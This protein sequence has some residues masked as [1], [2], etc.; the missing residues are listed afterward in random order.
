MANRKPIITSAEEFGID[1]TQLPGFMLDRDEQARSA[2]LRVELLVKT[3]PY[4]DRLI[5]N[6]H[7]T[8]DRILAAGFIDTSYLKYFSW[9]VGRCPTRNYI[10]IFNIDCTPSLFLNKDGTF[11]IELCEDLPRNLTRL[12]PEIE[13]YEIHSR[14]RPKDPMTVREIVHYGSARA[15]LSAAIAP[16]VAFPGEEEGEEEVAGWRWS[17]P[18]ERELVLRAPNGWFTYK[19][20]LELERQ[21]AERQT[22]DGGSRTKNTGVLLST[23]T[24]DGS[25]TPEALRKLITGNASIL[26]EMLLEQA[27]GSDLKGGSLGLWLHAESRQRLMELRGTVLATIENAEI[28][29]LTPQSLASV[30]RLMPRTQA[31]AKILHLVRQ[32]P[33]ETRD[34]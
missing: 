32:K 7:G 21:N 8:K 22:N 1:K 11:R 18:G 9:P 30:V 26:F 25:L 29:Q 2:G 34:A 20:D 13:R 4:S 31:T 33:Q 15:M 10:E 12:G 5:T 24:N 6:Y 16:P 3:S 27:K 19:R 28:C 14:D 17:D 23:R